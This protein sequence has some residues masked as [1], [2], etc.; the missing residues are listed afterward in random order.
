MSIDNRTDGRAVPPGF[1][2]YKFLDFAR[3]ELVPLKSARD[4]QLSVPAPPVLFP[5]TAGRLI[6]LALPSK[7]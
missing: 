6:G 4:A 1:V 5:L 3:G 2:L 7:G